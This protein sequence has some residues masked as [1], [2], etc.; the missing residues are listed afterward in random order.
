M[1]IFF[2][3]QSPYKAAQALHDRHVLSSINET[4][5]ILSTAWWNTWTGGLGS[6]EEHAERFKIPARP[7]K[8]A[9]HPL[10]LWAGTSEG[11]FKWVLTHLKSCL[12]EKKLRWPNTD[13]HSYSGYSWIRGNDLPPGILSK[14]FSNPPQ[15]VE[16]SY[17]RAPEEFI[18]AYRRYYRAFKTYYMAPNRKTPGKVHLVANSWTNR[19]M[20]E[21]LLNQ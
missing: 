4:A 20:P 6:Q 15:I 7:N 21:W 8:Y 12:L 19:G 1:N 9:R 13:P 14:E 18:L 3:D 2:L 17:K 16:D 11:N 5:Q 10:V